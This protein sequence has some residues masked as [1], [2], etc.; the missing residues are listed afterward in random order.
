MKVFVLSNLPHSHLTLPFLFLSFSLFLSLFLLQYSLPPLLPL[1]FPSSTFP[2]SISPSPSLP[3]SPT[4]TPLCPS[5]PPLL[6]LSLPFL[7]SSPPPPLSPLSPPL[8]LSLHF[9]SSLPLSLHPLL[10][11]L[12]CTLFLPFYFTS[13]LAS[14]SLLPLSPLLN[15]LHSS[16]LSLPSSSPHFLLP[17]VWRAIL[18][19]VVVFF[20]VGY[21]LISFLLWC[22]SW[23]PIFN[24][25][26]FPEW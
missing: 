15:H 4:L 12:Q 24:L 19:P 5:L 9:L 2:S 7:P 22:L 16:D 3:L 20:V 11:F 8:S 23:I 14:S 25:P 13:C 21:P 6:P 17:P 18:I 1:S 10:T 26:L